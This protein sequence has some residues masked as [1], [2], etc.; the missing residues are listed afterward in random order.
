MNSTEAKEKVVN[1]I[2][3]KGLEEREETLMVKEIYDKLYDY[4]KDHPEFSFMV[5]SYNSKDKVGT[6]FLLGD[7]DDIAKECASLMLYNKDHG[8]SRTFNKVFTRLF[9]LCRKFG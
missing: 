1:T 5:V 2:I 9:N 3:E 6:S 4:M 7:E 8:I